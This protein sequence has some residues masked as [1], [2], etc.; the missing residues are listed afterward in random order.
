MKH[1]LFER[2]G[3]VA[4]GEEILKDLKDDRSYIYVINVVAAVVVDVVVYW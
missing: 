4:G 2:R 1:H 3:S